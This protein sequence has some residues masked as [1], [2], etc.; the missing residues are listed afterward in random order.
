MTTR[1]QK[2]KAVAELVSGEFEDSVAENSLPENSVAAPSKTL[3][4]EPEYLD[5]IK[6]L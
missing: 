1:S 2:R 4:V 3:R 6:S 5:D